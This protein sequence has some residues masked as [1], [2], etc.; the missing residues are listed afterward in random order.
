[1]HLATLAEF[2]LAE[3]DSF[4][5]DARG[6]RKQCLSKNFLSF[7]HGR[8]KAQSVLVNSALLGFTVILGLDCLD[9][10]VAGKS[11]ILVCIDVTN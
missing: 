4:R 6:D 11:L 5:L 10:F 2:A 7:P 1:V 3:T 9:R 8:V